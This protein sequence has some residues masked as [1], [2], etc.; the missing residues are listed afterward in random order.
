MSLN[1]NEALT[2]F[3]L[4]PLATRRDTANLEVIYCAILRRGSKQ[5][6]QLFQGESSTRRSSPRFVCHNFQVI[7]NTRNLHRDFLD[8]STFGYVAIFNL[9]PQAVFESSEFDQPIPVKEFQR[10]LNN[11]LK[12]VGRIEVYWANMSSARFELHN[13]LI[14][15]FHQVS[16]SHLQ[17]FQP[18]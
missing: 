13:H 14:R 10:N 9:L 4:A 11:L 5:L 7:D 2:V 16:Y 15:G 18:H 12:F 17:S 3:N 6:Q 8:R 1:P